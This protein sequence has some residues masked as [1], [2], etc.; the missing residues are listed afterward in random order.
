MTK[1]RICVVFCL[2]TILVLAGLPSGV[3]TV[4]GQDGS[5][6]ATAKP[7][8][9]S[10]CSSV[11]VTDTVAVSDPGT[12][13]GQIERVFY[14]FTPSPIH[15][16]YAVTLD[17]PDNARIDLRATDTS[18]RLDL[19]LF[20]PIN[21]PS[22]YPEG[23]VMID[24]STSA[25]AGNRT[26]GPRRLEAARYLI[27]V[28]AQSGSSAYAV[29][30]TRGS[31]TAQALFVD[32]R[33][34]SAPVAA[35][36]LWVLNR[37]TPTR[38]P[39]ILDSIT[40]LLQSP[41]RTSDPSGQVLRFVVI[42]DPMGKGAPPPGGTPVVSQNLSLPMA[43]YGSDFRAVRFTGAGGASLGVRVLSGDFYAGFVAPANDGIGLL[44]DTDGLSVNAT[45]LSRDGGAT[46]SAA[47]VSEPYN[48]VVNA[49]VANALIR[50]S[51]TLPA[52]TP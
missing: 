32:H 15:D 47:T 52:C 46:F 38:Y 18:A 35:G 41:T 17:K 29:T 51:V 28:R 43:D 48:P 1:S 31:D 50:S 49:V 21:R 33:I 44:F 19:F 14:S 6:P 27:A 20:A 40:A 2:V 7:I 16:W 42:V 45:F 23:L 39:A 24:Y 13:I 5:S 34:T 9:V 22:Q 3:V 4:E 36:S 11:T 37:F 25:A 30:V 10:P 26:I 8:N 12:R